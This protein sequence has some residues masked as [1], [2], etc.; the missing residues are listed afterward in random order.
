MSTWAD[1]LFSLLMGW[2]HA[3]V[4]GV[5][6]LFSSD[7]TT[8]LAFLGKNWLT[9]ALIII[10]VGL[11][12]D[13]L[14]WLVRWQPY[15]LWARRARKVFRMDAPKDGDDEHDDVFDEDMLEDMERMQQE[16]MSVSRETETWDAEQLW[17]AE[18]M[19]YRPPT[20]QVSEEEAH[21]A[22]AQADS[23]P[24]D[25]QVRYP[26]MRYS[27]ASEQNPPS[28]TATGRHAGVSGPTRRH[29][30]LGG[31]QQKAEDEASR[32]ARAEEA[33][34]QAELERAR[35]ERE[36]EQAR[37]AQEAYEAEQTRLAQEEYARQMAEYE[38]QKAQYELEMAEYTRQKAEYDAAM[39]AQRM[40][41]EEQLMQAAGDSPSRRRRKPVSDSDAE[42]QTP[43]SPKMDA[44]MAR[45][46]KLVDDQD[47]RDVMGIASLPPR[48]DVNAAY[49]PAKK[50]T[51]RS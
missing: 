50:P 16:R 4:N 21:R 19:R 20:L 23:L 24:D 37:L 31:L 33:L 40:A 15:R 51:N 8:F 32:R 43:V 42:D 13:W 6:A 35:R 39:E 1:S 14:V 36:A 38:R 34:R 17:E 28:A 3:L 48:V 22:Y 25:T 30:Q 46:A 5:W 49:R 2:V 12:I 18:H 9:I 10:V 7:N 45:V 41:Y 44:L 26:G 27:A 29:A 11:V 47:E